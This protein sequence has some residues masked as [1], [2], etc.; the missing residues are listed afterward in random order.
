MNDLVTLTGSV[1][2]GEEFFRTGTFEMYCMAIEKHNKE[3]RP[4]NGSRGNNRTV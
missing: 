2:G 4:T 1:A 3:N